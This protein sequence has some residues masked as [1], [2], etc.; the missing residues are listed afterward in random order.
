MR[1][2]RHRRHVG[3]SAGRGICHYPNFNANARP[4][5]DRNPHTFTHTHPNRDLY[6]DCVDPND[7]AYAASKADRHAPIDASFVTLRVRTGYTATR[8]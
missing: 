3:L 4:H 1:W 5:C 8:D 6:A 7:N 2:T